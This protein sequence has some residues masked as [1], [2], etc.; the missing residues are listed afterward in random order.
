I[1]LCVHPITV[2]PNQSTEFNFFNSFNA[3]LRTQWDFS[4]KSLCDLTPPWVTKGCLRVLSKENPT[5]AASSGEGG[6]PVLMTAAKMVL[7][8]W[9]RGTI[10]FFVHPQSKTDPNTSVNMK[11]VTWKRKMILSRNGLSGQL[12]VAMENLA[13]LVTFNVSH[14]QLHVEL[15][16]GAFL[17]T[18]SPSS[19]AGNP[20]LCGAAV[21]C[22]TMLPKPIV[23]NLNSTES[24]LPCPGQQRQSLYLEAVSTAPPVS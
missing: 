7:H 6:E 8:D 22:P 17:N 2:A 23:L 13:H 11:R 16:G 3:G 24:D 20:A 19:I 10:P 12:P 14:N 4:F 21:D 18:I 1:A 15:P 5:L 9:Q